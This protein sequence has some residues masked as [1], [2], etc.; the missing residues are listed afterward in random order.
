M[1]EVFRGPSAV[2]LKL[3]QTGDFEF[4]VFVCYS[5]RDKDWVANHLQPA[6]EGKL[7][8]KVPAVNSLNVSMFMLVFMLVVTLAWTHLQSAF[9][10]ASG[11]LNRQQQR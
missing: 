9:V 3:I 2:R 4:D 10:K 8:L 11:T 5:A 7:R 1:Y 6:L